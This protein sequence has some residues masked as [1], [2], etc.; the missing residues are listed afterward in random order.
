MRFLLETPLDDL[1]DALS[2]A[3]SARDA[4]LDG[5][6][7]HA[8]EL[9]PA[10]LVTAAAIAGAIPD[11]LIGARVR[12]GDRHP[13]EVAEEV[14]VVDHLATGRL[15]L[16]AE[17]AVGGD[18]H[19][20]EALDL[21]RTALAPRPFRFEGQ[22][23]RVPAGL[24]QNIHNAEHRVRVTPAPPR[25]Q[26]T[27][28]TAGQTLAI[29]LE[30]ALGYVAECDHDDRSL[31]SAFAEAEAGRS[32][33]LAGV[34]RARYE[35]LRHPAELVARLSNGQRAFGQDWA[36]VEAASPGTAASIIGREVKPRVQLD[37]LPAGLEALWAE[38]E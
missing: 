7:V 9:L 18:E 2:A 26:V 8:T 13:I 17:P 19:F 14:S 24:P 21:L 27:I 32:S 6:V 29:A 12:L 1:T 10:P 35:R 25:P 22:R 37:A 20:G 34:P 30:R 33:L 16:I 11:I 23:W 28:W 15:V 3:A 31:Q 38:E 4:G 36:I 5:V